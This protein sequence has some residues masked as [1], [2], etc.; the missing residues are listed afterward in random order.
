MIGKLLA[1]PFKSAL[2]AAVFLFLSFAAFLSGSPYVFALDIPLLSMVFHMM[3]M[4]VI[5]SL[6]IRVFV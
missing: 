2:H 4:L 1:F 6:V 5:A 3:V